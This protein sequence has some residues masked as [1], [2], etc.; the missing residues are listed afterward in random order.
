LPNEPASASAA[1]PPE[2]PHAS[3]T[4]RDSVDQAREAV[5]ALTSRTAEEALGKTRRLLAKVPDLSVAKGATI[6]PP[7]RTLREAGAG[8]TAGLAPLTDSARRAVDLFL[9]DLPPIELGAHRGL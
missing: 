5:V 6:E 1:R 9:R 4:L 7:V 3:T 8:V 2:A